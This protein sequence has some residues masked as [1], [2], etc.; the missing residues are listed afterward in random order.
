[1]NYLLKWTFNGHSYELLTTRHE[2]VGDFLRKI[3]VP[4][5]TE[6]SVEHVPTG[7]TV[8]Q[9]DAKSAAITAKR[10]PLTYIGAK[11]E[12]GSYPEWGAAYE[13]HHPEFDASCEPGEGWSS[14]G[15]AGHGKTI[16]DCMEQIDEFVDKIESDER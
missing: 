7:Q 1:M 15:G 3:E 6:V 5:M 8:C 12:P 2:A 16:E 11:I 10:H 13:W 9:W 14:N 4:A